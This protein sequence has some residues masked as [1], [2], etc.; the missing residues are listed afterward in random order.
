MGGPITN[1]HRALLLVAAVAITA[2]G[3]FGFFQR[4]DIGRGGFTYSP[5]YLVNYVEPEG[6]G[7]AAG[8]QV[9]DRVVSVEGIPVEELPLYSRW[10]HSLIRRPGESL[11]LVV[12]REGEPLSLGVVYGATPR[13][14]L[15]LRL[16]VALVGLAF[17][18]FG[19]W[20]LFSVH[21]SHALA[22]AG[23]GL[24]AGMATFGAGPYLGTWDGVASHVQFAAMLLLSVL[25]LRFFLTFPRLKRAGASRLVTGVIYAVW[26]LF[27]ACLV[28]ELIFHPTLYHTFGSLGMLLML[29]YCVLALV[30]VA[31][32]VVTTPRQELSDSGMSLILIGIFVAVVSLFLALSSG[33]RLPG[34]AYAPLLIVAIPVSM[35][36]AVRKQARAT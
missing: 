6:G 36:L 35:A 2:W 10:P 1:R 30:A 19:L 16:G 4:L 13:G 28:L 5:E 25:L 8:L 20:P 3:T 31:H 14:V 18:V 26:V 9:G 34:S 11:R 29:G 23:I 32:T 21:T 33:F 7:R 12:E 27:V 17:L 15:N 22:L 24:A